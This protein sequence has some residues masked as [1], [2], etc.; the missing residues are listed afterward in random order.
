MGV[1]VGVL[2]E[3]FFGAWKL[4]LSGTS[5]DVWMRYSALGSEQDSVSRRHE[6][7]IHPR[8]MPTVPA[9]AAGYQQVP[10]DLIA[11]RACCNPESTKPRP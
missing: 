6:Q 10:I 3:C 2:L 9:R 4:G 7:D 1:D 8:N 11:L 5:G